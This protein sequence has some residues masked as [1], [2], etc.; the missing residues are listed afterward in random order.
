ME[1]TVA[2]IHLMTDIKK[3]LSYLWYQELYSRMRN[4]GADEGSP[5][6]SKKLLAEMMKPLPQNEIFF[7]TGKHFIAAIEK[8]RTVLGF[9]NET[10]HYLL[11]YL[12]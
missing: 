2:A 9:K 5:I 11:R 12:V 4:E 3:V 8:G 6:D 1:N 10:V 7:R